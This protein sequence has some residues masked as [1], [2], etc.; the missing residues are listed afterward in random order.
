MLKLDFENQIDENFPDRVRGPLI[1][2]LLPVSEKFS[3]H[4][5]LKCR[6]DVFM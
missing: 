3:N 6:T 1:F 5:P 4:T 2:S